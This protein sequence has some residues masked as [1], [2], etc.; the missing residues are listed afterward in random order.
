MALPSLA[1]FSGNMDAFRAFAL[2][3]SI[4]FHSAASRLGDEVGTK[5][6]PSPQA[7]VTQFAPCYQ[8][9]GIV[10]VTTDHRSA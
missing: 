4:T 8:R 5:G 3:L 6:R 2:S 7:L 1:I 9:T 10:C